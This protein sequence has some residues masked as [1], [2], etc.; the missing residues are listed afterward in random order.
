MDYAV[1]DS[2]AWGRAPCEARRMMNSSWAGGS[3]GGFPDKITKRKILNRR[4]GL[5]KKKHGSLKTS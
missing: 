3:Q 5:T 4:N 1:S 2:G